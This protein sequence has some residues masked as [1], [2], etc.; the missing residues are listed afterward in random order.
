MPGI[1][2]ALIHY[3]V[4][5]KAPNEEFG[6][7]FLDEAQDFGIGIYYVLRTLLPAT[8]FT[9]MG[10]VSQNIHYDTGLN[11]W[12]ELQK[13]FL[14]NERDEFLLLQKSYRNTIEI[15]EYAG[16]I[17]E[18]ASFGRYRIEPVIRHG[19]PVEETRFWSDLEMAEHA[20][21]LIDAIGDKGYH[22]TAI[23]CQ[24][25]TEADRVRELLSPMTSLTDG[26]AS[27]FST[28]TMILP[29]RLVK[30]LEFDAVILWNLDMQHGPDDPRLAKLLYVAEVGGQAVLGCGCHPGIAR[31]SRAELLICTLEGR[32][33]PD[34]P[35]SF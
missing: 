11:D 2:R 32:P 17:L 15:S 33:A 28:G 1:R 12:Y 16:R 30:G 19:I 26:A 10:D 8:Y 5:Q 21:R 14:K 3:R 20:A 23:I 22:T 6:L 24:S 29:I 31:T 7:L 4:Y 25:E 35:R 13:L 34:V 9:I 27:N 18:K